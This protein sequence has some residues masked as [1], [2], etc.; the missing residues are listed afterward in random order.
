MKISRPYTLKERI[1]Q[2]CIR[3]HYFNAGTNEQY[4][5]M[6][7]AACSSQFS[8]RDVAV[9]IS[10]CSICADVSKVEQQI[11]EIIDE[12]EAGAA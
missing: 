8:V 6:F 11:Q 10:M 4:N 7:Y 9:M 1:Y 5:M 3:E 2:L 12:I